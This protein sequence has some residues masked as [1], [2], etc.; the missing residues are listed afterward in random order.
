MGDAEIEHPSFTQSKTPILTSDGAKSDV[1]NAPKAT[2][3]PQDPD[4]AMVV[5][6]W[7]NLPEHIKAAIKVLVKTY[8]QG[9]SQ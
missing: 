4:L 2:Q 7:P 1:P 5:K 9:D 6:C 8:F 3:T